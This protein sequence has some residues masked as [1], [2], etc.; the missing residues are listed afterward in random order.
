MSLA[1]N[2]VSPRVIM[3]GRLAEPA[4]AKAPAPPPAQDSLELR[5][6]RN[7]APITYSD[8]RKARTAETDPAR[9]DLQAMLEA[10]KKQV[11]D[12]M[13]YLQ[14][15][16]EKQGL[17][18]AKLASGEQRLTADPAAIEAAKAAIAEDGEFG[19]RKTA[20]R[21]LSFAKLA[22]GNDPAQLE[23]IRAAVQ[24]GFDQAR[25]VFGGTLPQI[26]EDTYAAIMGE[27]DRWA[28]EGMPAGDTVSLAKS[29]A[30]APAAA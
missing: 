29:K 15:L 23:N 25:Q 10:S 28:T 20:E 8:P 21:I 18:L 9:P 30:E 24:K 12:I 7:E 14:P 2:T 22:T 16:L 26:S 6:R 27:L 19:V 13:A 3:P 4:Q 1:I 11:A 17:N 5:S